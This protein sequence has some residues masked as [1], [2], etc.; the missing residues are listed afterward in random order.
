MY[1]TGYRPGLI[2]GRATVLGRLVSWGEVKMTAQVSSS[3]AGI[4]RRGIFSN[5]KLWP[6]YDPTTGPIS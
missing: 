4:S 5:F 3:E 6:N 2:P 1:Y